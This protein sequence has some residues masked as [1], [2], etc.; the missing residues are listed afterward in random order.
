MDMVVAAGG[1]ERDE[2]VDAAIL[3]ASATPQRP[4]RP[5]QREADHRTAADAVPGAAFQ[6]A[7]RQ[8][9]DRPQ[10]H[11][12]VAHLHGRGRRRRL[13]R[14]DRRRAASASGQCD[15]YAGRRRLPDRTPRHAA[16]LRARRLPASRRRGSPSGSARARKAAASIIGLRR[17]PSSCWNRASMPRSAGGKAYARLGPVVSDR[18][19]PPQAAT[20]PPRSPALAGQGR[21][22]PATSPCSRFP[23][24]PARH[25][26]H[27][28]RE[29]EHS[30]P[31]PSV[32]AARL[33]QRLSGHLKEAQFPFAV[34]LAALAV[35]QSGGLPAFDPDD[36]DA[37]RRR[38]QRGRSQRRSAITGRGHGAHRGRELTD[39]DDYGQTQRSSR[40][41]RRRRH[42]HRHRHL[43]R[44]RQDGQLGGADRR[45][46][47]ASTRS[48]AFPPTI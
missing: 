7:R 12:L 2:A 33:R 6:P 11:R 22:L 38:R 15:A 1:G 19:A 20:S 42:R 21:H 8:H 34:A 28:G 14:R 18:V 46:A 47:P 24:P 3:A 9:L 41:A 48:R 29:R 45:A 16:R 17:R 39:E 26:A 5:A 36:G 10:G 30:M 31:I 25:A 32:S 23:A 27:G 35:A 43:A 13:R 37:I 40:T 44:R 4:R